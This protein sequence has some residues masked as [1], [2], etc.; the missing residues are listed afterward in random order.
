LSTDSLHY[1]AH[2]P[3]QKFILLDSE[4]DFGGQLQQRICNK[5]NVKD[6]P[7]GYWKSNRELVWVKL[8]KKRNNVIEAICKTMEGK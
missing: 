1:K 6:D 7:K 3:Y 4:L 8:A 2:F 5:L